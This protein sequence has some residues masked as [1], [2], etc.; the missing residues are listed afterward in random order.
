VYPLGQ[1]RLGPSIEAFVQAFGREGLETR[2]GA[3]STL[4]TGDADRVFAALR[5]G[6]SKAAMIAP[7]VLTVTIS[8]SCLVAER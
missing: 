5:E 3:M 2:V 4:V 7:T 6:F 8:N 1:E